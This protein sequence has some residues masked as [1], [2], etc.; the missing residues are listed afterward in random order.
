MQVITDEDQSLGILAEIIETGAKNVFVV[1]RE[2]GSEILLPDI[3]EVVMEIDVGN[4]LMKV[5]L[6][7]G[8][9]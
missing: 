3:E 2:D 8:L 1:R 6:I 9:I 4:K 5:H 7:E